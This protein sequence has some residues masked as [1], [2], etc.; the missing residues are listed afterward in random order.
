M[1]F[2][3]VVANNNILSCFFFFFF[4]IDFLIP[5]V[6]AQIYNPI[7]ELVI[8]TGITNKKAKSEIEIHL[9]ISEV[10]IRKRSM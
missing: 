6:I 4:T 3:W 9:V 5:A 1:L 10:K 2:N 7:A 8:P